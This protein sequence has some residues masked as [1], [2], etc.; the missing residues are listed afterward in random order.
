[1]SVDQLKKWRL[2]L[3]LILAAAVNIVL[4][5]ATV[6][7][8]ADY[9]RIG[10]TKTAGEIE[11]RI[12]GTDGAASLSLARGGKEEEISA[13]T[14]GEVVTNGIYLYFAEYTDA[15]RER[16]DIFR[17]NIR[18][19]QRRRLLEDQ[20]K[21][22]LLGAIGDFLYVGLPSEFGKCLGLYVLNI[23]TGSYER[24]LGDCDYRISVTDSLILAEARK[25]PGRECPL[26]V[27]NIDGSGRKK[28]RKKAWAAVLIGRTVYYERNTTPGAEKEHKRVYTCNTDGGEPTPR[29]AWYSGD[30][31]SKY[32]FIETGYYG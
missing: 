8:V 17:Y 29:T 28:I 6:Q 23:K 12:D 5:S 26:Y 19:G 25:R 10:E 32:G 7:P 24:V 4:V 9:T 20:E 18:S 2:P 14:T 16:A 22:V 30:I 27:L 15:E 11:Y 3:F 1:M 31:P 21:P 13:R